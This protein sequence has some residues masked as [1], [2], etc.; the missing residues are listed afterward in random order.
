M[1]TTTQMNP[2]HEAPA[3]QLPAQQLPKH[4]QDSEYLSDFRNRKST[5]EMFDDSNPNMTI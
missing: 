2:A 1:Y 4:F 5:K 3:Q